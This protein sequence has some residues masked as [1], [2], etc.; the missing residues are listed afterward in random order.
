MDFAATTEQRRMIAGARRFASGLGRLGEGLDESDFNK[1]GWEA[2]AQYGVLGWLTPQEYGGAGL[3]PLSAALSL[4]ALGAGC[5]DNGLLFA[6]NNHLFAC[7]TYLLDHGTPEQ[8]F[9]WLPALASGSV[10]GAHALTEVTAGSD[11]LS[12]RTVARRVGDRFVIDG[13]KTYVSN[14]PVAG[15]FVVFARTDEGA[16]GQASIS[17][18]L[19]PST[20]SGVT[21]RP[22]AKMGLGGTPMG[23]VTFEDC[24]VPATSLLGEPGGA[25]QMF[26]TGLVW[27]RGF[28]FATQVG[29]LERLLDEMV[30]HCNERRQFGRTIGSNQSVAHRIADHKVRVETS[31][32]LLH[33]MAWKVKAGHLAI[34]EACMLKLWV[35]EALKSISLDLLQLRGAAGFLAGAPAE[36][37]V[38]DSLAATIYGGTSEIQRSAIAAM[39]GLVVSGASS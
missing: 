28:M 16:P 32:L 27:E 26:Q 11:V 21:V 38:R 4:E 22:L 14:G 36:R 5:A 19:V 30:A 2:C 23:E 29:A 35:S 3:D 24:A 31:K 15:L 13:R 1:A 39:S 6:V 20:Q 8:R 18:F 9:E 33:K 7:T 12:M 17:A 25:Y 37:Q 34:E 10:I